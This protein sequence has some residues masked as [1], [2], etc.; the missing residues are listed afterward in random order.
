MSDKLFYLQTSH[1]SCS[2]E[3]DLTIDK[4][5]EDKKIWDYAFIVTVIAAAVMPLFLTE[6]DS[7]VSSGGQPQSGRTYTPTSQFDPY[8]AQFQY[9]QTNSG[10]T[11]IA[12][13][14][15]TFRGG[16]ST[17]FSKEWMMR[18]GIGI[19]SS[20][21]SKPD[22]AKERCFTVCGK[23]YNTKDPS[24][25][26]CKDF[27]PPKTTTGAQVKRDAAIAGPKITL[28]YNETSYGEEFGCAGGAKAALCGAFENARI[29]LSLITPS[30]AV[31]ALSDTRTDSL[32]NFDVS[33]NAPAADGTFNAVLKVK[34][35]PPV[36]ATTN[37]QTTAAT[38]VS[39]SQLGTNR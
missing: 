3:Y 2:G 30:G 38:Q 11:N 33:F 29:D 28:S 5:G 39:T 7:G 27:V 15:N 17:G 9:Q 20:F 13:I 19:I 35:V 26:T 4:V 8:S 10:G 16:G 24:K 12:G 18:F 1:Q 14:L 23:V 31:T 36:G 6:V 25:D 22:P 34:G 37:Q 21:F 32:G